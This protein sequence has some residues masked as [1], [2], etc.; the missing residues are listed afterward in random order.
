MKYA[1]RSDLFEKQVIWQDETYQK[2][3][4]TYPVISLTFANIKE[5]NFVET[6]RRICQI[7]V[8]LY[9]EHS[10]LLNSGVL[11]ASDKEYFNRVSVDMRDS[12]ASIALHN[13]SKYLYRYYGKKVIIL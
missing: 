1:G 11:A 3:Q 8:D 7:L 4:G 10:F 6:R 5:N 13:L 9:A 2:L 12:D